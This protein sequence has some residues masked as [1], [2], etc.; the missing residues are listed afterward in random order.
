MTSGAASWRRKLLT[1][2]LVAAGGLSYAAV[3]MTS[4]SYIHTP[5]VLNKGGHDA[6]ASTSYANLAT[7]DEPSIGQASS[8]SYQSDVGFI[9][10][11]GSVPW[12]HITAG[13][14]PPIVGGGG[15]ASITW[16]SN[17]A[18]SYTITQGTTTVVSGTVAANTPVVSTI[19]ASAL[20]ADTTNTIV[21][22]VT[23]TSPPAGYTNPW[24]VS[25]TL[26]DDRTAPAV[27]A[28]DMTQLTG[29]VTDASITSLTVQIAGQPDTVVPVTGGTF[30]VSYPAG[31]T[32]ITLLGG[33]FTR[34]VEVIP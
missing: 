21:I 20:A 8:S 5:E 11:L 3:V 16:H 25:T 2:A 4:T 13:P 23:A 29:H 24:S 17:F 31:T 32:Q 19:P 6:A 1:V 9:Y 10:L 27:T 14:T 26:V 7:I 15:S 34:I 28:F 33:G 22:T 12:V 30:T 18:G